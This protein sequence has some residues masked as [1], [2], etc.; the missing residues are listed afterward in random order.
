MVEYCCLHTKFLTLYSFA[1]DCIAH[2]SSSNNRE[3]ANKGNHCSANNYI[4]CY[5]SK[6]RHLAQRATHF[7][8]PTILDLNQVPF[9][10]A[11]KMIV[12]SR[13]RAEQVGECRASQNNSFFEIG[14]GLSQ[15][16]LLLGL[17]IQKVVV[18]EM[19]TT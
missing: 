15:E 14:T 7:H 8:A 11:V 18:L 10:C 9:S 5:C 16:F 1:S 2:C 6:N 4:H 12:E 19:G 17:L 3:P 13:P